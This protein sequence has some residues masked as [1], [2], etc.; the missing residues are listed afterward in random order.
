MGDEEARVISL[1][2]L[3]EAKKRQKKKEKLWEGRE[4]IYG[5]EL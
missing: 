4:I 5:N 1:E 2:K 3:W